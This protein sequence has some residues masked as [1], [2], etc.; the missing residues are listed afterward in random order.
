MIIFR[1]TNI[2]VLNHDTGFW[3]YFS[4]HINR[5][6]HYLF[7]AN[8]FSVLLFY[9]NLNKKLDA[10]LEIANYSRLIGDSDRIKFCQDK[11]KILKIEYL[12]SDFF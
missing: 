11:L 1:A 10:F 5:C 9:F 4:F 3:T 6:L 12:I 7:E 8:G 2:R